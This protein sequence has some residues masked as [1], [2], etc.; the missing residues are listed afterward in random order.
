[1]AHIFAAA[2]FINYIYIQIIGFGIL[3]NYQPTQIERKFFI[4][5]TMPKN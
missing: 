2:S 4:Q 3:S 1:M 5:K